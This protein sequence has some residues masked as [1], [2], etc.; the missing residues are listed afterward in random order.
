M[1]QGN[2]RMAKSSDIE[3]ILEI[4]EEHFI[5]NKSEEELSV[6]CLVGKKSATDLENFI[7]NQETHVL[8]CEMFN[9]IVGY[10]I[11]SPGFNDINAPSKVVSAFN[12]DKSISNPDNEVVSIV[13][14]ASA[15]KYK[16]DGVADS[17]YKFWL[18]K[19]VSNQVEYCIGE[20]NEKNQAS[21]SFFSK[22]DWNEYEESYQ[23]QKK[24]DLSWGLWY[25]KNEISTG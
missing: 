13:H 21:R 17:L 9:K 11:S 24:P 4:Q 12:N 3:R 7:K 1:S 5:G 25:F 6:G 19:V 16:G 20:I 8:V 22:R 14:I 15:V 23:W 10:L 2:T 18:Q